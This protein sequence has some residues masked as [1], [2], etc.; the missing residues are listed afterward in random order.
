M[1]LHKRRAWE[2]QTKPRAHKRSQ[3][4]DG[5]RSDV[6]RC[7]P[8]AREGPVQLEKVGIPAVRANSEQEG[9]RLIGQSAKRV[10][11][12][13]RRC[14]IE[15]LEVVDGDNDRPRAR[16]P[17]ECAENRRRQRQRVPGIGVVGRRPEQ[18][19]LERS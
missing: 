11:Q 9:K 16:Q 12:H 18:R 1:Q 17:S 14:C 10:A 5:Q 4:I 8:V 7:D 13:V 15:P 6:K 19:D 2:A 3:L